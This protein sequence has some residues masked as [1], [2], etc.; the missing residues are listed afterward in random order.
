MI[1]GWEGDGFVK[2][3]RR[4]RSTWGTPVG[5][6]PLRFTAPTYP[7]SFKRKQFFLM[8]SPNGRA[9]NF[10]RTRSKPGHRRREA[11]DFKRGKILV[12]RLR[13]PPEARPVEPDRLE[14]GVRVIVPEST[15]ELIRVDSLDVELFEDR[16][17]EIGEI[18]CDEEARPAVNR[19]RQ[20]VPVVGV[21]EDECRDEG[22]VP[23]HEAIRDMLIHKPPAPLQARR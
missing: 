22:L 16:S 9:S 11:T 13:R 14:N 20:D 5:R 15:N 1:P 17:R 18:E 23:A 3:S 4:S 10:R 8:G 7:I 21:G 2:Y 19:R 12:R 6:V